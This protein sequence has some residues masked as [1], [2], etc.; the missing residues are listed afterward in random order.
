MPFLQMRNL[1]VCGVEAAVFRISFT[2]EAGYLDTSETLPRHSYTLL[3]H[4]TGEAGYLDTSE[5]LLDTA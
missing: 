1:R 5:T 3:R 4:F 2:G